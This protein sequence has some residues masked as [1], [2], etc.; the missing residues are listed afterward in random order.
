MIQYSDHQFSFLFPPL[1]LSSRTNE[2]EFVSRR[3]VIRTSSGLLSSLQRNGLKLFAKTGDK[4]TCKG[5][6]GG[7][8]N[9][10][11]DK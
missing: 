8:F 10:L 3:N 9:D 7:Q 11:I 5:R 4:E 2:S 6:L 1:H